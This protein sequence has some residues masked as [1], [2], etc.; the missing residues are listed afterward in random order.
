MIVQLMSEIWTASDEYSCKHS[1]GSDITATVILLCA[2]QLGS[3]LSMYCP[4]PGVFTDEVT[5]AQSGKVACL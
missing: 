5:E 3:A 2:S 1:P 4:Y